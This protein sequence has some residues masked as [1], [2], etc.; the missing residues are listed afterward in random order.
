MGIARLLIRLLLAA[1]MVQKF[2][3]FMS[4]IVRSTCSIYVNILVFGGVIKKTQLKIKKKNLKKKS[5]SIINSLHPQLWDAFC[6]QIS[7]N[8]HR[9]TEARCWPRQHINSWPR[10]QSTVVEED[11][12]NKRSKD[13]WVAIDQP[14]IRV[15]LT[16]TKV[17]FLGRCKG[18]LGI[19]Y[20]GYNDPSICN[21]YVYI[22]DN[23]IN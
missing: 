18:Y 5:G 14:N 2:R 19:L 11:I 4:H 20:T 17:G 7:A 13:T 9:F 23:P 10:S 3:S 6:W 15:T 12:A 21:V 16:L 22:A 1:S 8:S